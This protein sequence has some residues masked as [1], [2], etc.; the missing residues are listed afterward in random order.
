MYSSMYLIR[1]DFVLTRKFMLLLIPYY[2][3]MGY[4]NAEGYTLFSLFPAMLM[5]VNAC[6]IDMQ[7]NN[8]KFLVSLPLPRQR[9]VLAKYLTLIPFTL[10]SLICTLLL[11]SFATI[12]GRLDEP[13]RWRELG[14]SVAAFP[15]LASF[16]LPLYYWL[17]QKGKQV[18]NFVFIMLIMFNITALSSLTKRYPALSEW[19]QTGNISNS[20]IVVIGI[21]AYI[22]IIYGSYLLSLRIFSKKDI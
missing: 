4:T 9:L 5:L 6:T 12:M 17:G 18:V 10:F 14:L 21:L 20:V 11:F 15:L 2:L 8:L 22:I 1:K 16:Y 19:V 7:N 3:L 13:L